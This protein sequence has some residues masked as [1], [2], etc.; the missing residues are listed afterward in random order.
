MVGFF[1]LSA[2]LR[3]KRY[4]LA[5]VQPTPLRV[6]STWTNIPLRRDEQEHEALQHPKC[7]LTTNILLASR[8]AHTEATSFL[9][10]SNTFCIS[11]GDILDF[12]NKPLAPNPRSTCAT[13]AFSVS[14]ITM[15]TRSKGHST[16]SPHC[17]GCVRFSFPP[18][19]SELESSYVWRP[20]GRK[21]YTPLAVSR[22]AT[23]SSS[24]PAASSSDRLEVGGWSAAPSR[25][26]LRG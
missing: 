21:S 9:Y 22:T 16:P 1:D 4:E 17:Q 11:A 18:H 23:S 2:E 10:G 6:G 14:T 25:A 20:L 26:R 13:F 8:A 12:L 15:N 7:D 3:N 19:I 5:L 24:S